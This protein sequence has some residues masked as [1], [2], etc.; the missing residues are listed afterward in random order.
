MAGDA[1]PDDRFLPGQ[2]PID[3]VLDQGFRFGDM[4]HR[5]SLIAVPGRT[6]G[7]VPPASAARLTPADLAP[8]LAAA[9]AVDILVLG[10]GRDIAVLPD[11]T[12]EALRA[13]GLA[14]EVASTRTAVRTYNILLSEN[15]RVAAALM[16]LT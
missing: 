8:V 3:S 14:L 10:T 11:D 4:S 7:W 5:G 9:D 2:P 12:V 13:A 6:Q 15:R 1:T 16:A